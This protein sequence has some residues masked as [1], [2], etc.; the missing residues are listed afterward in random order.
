[1]RVEGILGDA[2]AAGEVLTIPRVHR[3]P[4][5]GRYAVVFARK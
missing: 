4:K 3:M 5:R 1:M 2:F